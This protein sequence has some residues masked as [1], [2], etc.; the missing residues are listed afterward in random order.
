MRVELLDDGERGAEDV[1]GEVAHGHVVR[2]A[3]LVADLFEF[4][5]RGEGTHAQGEGAAE[6]ETGAAGGEPEGEFVLKN[7]RDGT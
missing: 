1:L 7:K 4:P 5:A 6:A 2:E 3:D